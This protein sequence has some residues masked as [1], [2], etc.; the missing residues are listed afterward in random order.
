MN[1]HQRRV[2]KRATGWRFIGIGCG[3]QFYSGAC[4]YPDLSCWDSYLGDDDSDG[5]DPSTARIPCPHCRPTEYKAWV[6]D[7]GEQPISYKK[8][9]TQ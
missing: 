5:Y 7:D 3:T 8:G 4:G 1:A 2:A 9:G 6:S